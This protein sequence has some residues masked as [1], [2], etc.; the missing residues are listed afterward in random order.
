MSSQGTT[1]GSENGTAESAPASGRSLKRVITGVTN[2]AMT[3]ACA[4]ITAGIFSLFAFALESSGPAFF[5]GWLIVGG[6]VFLAC[7]NYAELASHFPFAASIYH[8]PT[9]LAGRRAGWWVGWL[10][11]GALLA[12]LPAYT[13]VMP[14]VLGPLFGFTPSRW[15]IVG[16]SVGF[17]VI[18]MSLNMLGIDILGRLTVAGVVA[19]LLVLF[20]LSLLVYAFG[21]HNSPSILFNA[22]GTGSTFS[23]WLPG[24]LGG[25]IFVGLWALFTFETAGTLGEETIDAKRQ[26]PKAI[27]GAAA[28]SVIAGAVFLFL[29]ILS[30]PNLPAAMKSASPIQDTISNSLST[31]AAKLYL[32]VMAW[33]LFLAINMLFTAI[34]RHIFGMARAAQLPFSSTLSRTRANGEPWVAAIVIAVLTSLPLI[35]I[36]Q[37][38]TVLVTGAIAAIYVPYVLVLGIT[39]FA[40]LRGWPRSTAP[41]SLGRW[42]IPINLAALALAVATLVDLMWPRD[43]TNP[44]WKL[45]IRVSYWLVGIPLVIGIVYYALQMHARLAGARE[46]TAAE[47][48]TDPAVPDEM[49]AQG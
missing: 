29:I 26:A 22:G 2:G 32:V 18:G 12:L 41:F 47:S 25:G 15:S 43:T 28:L 30:I 33:V 4:G 5:W 48:L 46:V 27:L 39:L 16:I 3:Y 20:V 7:L 35:I 21:P 40:R 9:Y 34:S 45:D 8:W 23:A 31:G 13:I 11:L 44:V 6:S 19:E 38:L 37:N 36:T 24:F 42:G 14:A 1:L 10:Y 17:I 49:L